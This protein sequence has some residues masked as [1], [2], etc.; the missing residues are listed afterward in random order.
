[1]KFS[2]RAR[3]AAGGA[4]TR[5]PYCSTDS[6][7]ATNRPDGHHPGHFFIANSGSLT[8]RLLARC[9][10]PLHFARELLG[11]ACLLKNIVAQ[12]LVALAEVAS[13][14]GTETNEA[15]IRDELSRLGALI[16]AGMA[17]EG[18]LVRCNEL[19]CQLHAVAPAPALR[20]R[21]EDAQAL[22]DQIVVAQTLSVEH[23]H[24]LLA[25]G[26]VERA[27][28]ALGRLSGPIR[29]VEP[30]GAAYLVAIYNLG[31]DPLIDLSRTQ[32]RVE[33]LARLSEIM[34]AGAGF[35]PATFGL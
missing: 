11:F 10:F 7:T 5:S 21:L 12:E 23:V 33:H 20:I 13:R 24:E 2:T 26:D 14:S 4:T 28:D 8:S 19:T 34:V 25:E 1:M 6:P 15:G 18:A 17:T 22:A 29:I 9:I 16:A 27:R 35:E 31:I 32:P 30:P 3:F